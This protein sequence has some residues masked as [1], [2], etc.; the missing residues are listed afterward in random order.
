VECKKSIQGRFTH[1]SYERN[2]KYKLDLVG[3]QVRWDRCGTK[4]AGFLWKG[5]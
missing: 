5:E 1:D 3:V 4:P 2:I